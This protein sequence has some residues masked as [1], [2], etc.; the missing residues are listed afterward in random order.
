MIACLCNVQ[1]KAIQND[2]DA[3]QIERD[4]HPNHFV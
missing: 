2:L 1:W 4:A 3:A